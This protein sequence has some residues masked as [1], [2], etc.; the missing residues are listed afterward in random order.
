MNDVGSHYTRE[1][2]ILANPDAYLQA[3]QGGSNSNVD[4]LKSLLSK[5]PIGG[6]SSDEKMNEAEDLHAESKAYNFDPDDV[7]PPEI[8]A[9]M[10]ELLKW[11]DGVYRDILEKIEMIPGLSDL[12]DNLTNALNACESCGW[13][14]LIE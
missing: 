4:T 9:K 1:T 11:R 13:T 5:L 3:S 6:G 8:Q 7:A 12:L 2:V 14:K 10:L